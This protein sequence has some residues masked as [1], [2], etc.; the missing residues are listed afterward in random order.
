MIDGYVAKL[1][2]LTAGAWC[3][4]TDKTMIGLDQGLLHFQRMAREADSLGRKLMFI[5]NGGSAAIASH[6]AIDYSKNGG[7]KAVAFNDAVAL[8]CMANDFGYEN[9]FS[10]M[11]T[12]SARGYDILVAVSSSGRSPNIIA[13]CAAARL[14]GCAIVTFSGFDE[15]N[16]LRALGDLNFYVNSH[17]YG[18]VEIAH[19]TLLH[20][21]L[22]RLE[23]E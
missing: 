15:A 21:V 12:A 20:A 6:M 2:D 23:R 8:T 4:T 22:D 7:V 3:S 17:E 14:I 9:V 13:A 10:M 18:F 19:L 16:P 5:G 11:V 1:W